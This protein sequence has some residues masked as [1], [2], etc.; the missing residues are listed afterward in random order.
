MENSIEV[1]LASHRE[2]LPQGWLP[3][4]RESESSAYG[5]RLQAQYAEV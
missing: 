4:C 2:A 1:A 5:L 3:G